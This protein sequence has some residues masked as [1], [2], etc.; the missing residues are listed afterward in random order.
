MSMKILLFVAAIAGMMMSNTTANESLYNIP[1]NDIKGKK[2]SLK[3]YEGKV[4]L[5]VNVA[6]KC[7]YTSQYEGLQALYS[8]YKDKGL[9]VIGFPSNDFGRQEPGTD[10]EILTFCKSKY[11]VTFP[12]MSKI[13]VKGKEKHPLYKAITEKPSPM[14][15]E[16]S[17]NFNK[18]LVDKT[19][20]LAKRYKSGVR[21]N[22][23]NIISDIEKLL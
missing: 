7:G 13:K 5:M 8:K 10:L 2:T 11:D 21:P 3:K 19:G 1:F 14:P 20:K 17:W 12:M 23:K 6:S 15:G 18:V 4:I 9:V 22:S 16:I